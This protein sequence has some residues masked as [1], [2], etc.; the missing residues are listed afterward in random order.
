[1]R[2]KGVGVG[3]LYFYVHFVT[4][5]IC[6]TLL[7]R[8][9]CSG[10]E[11]WALYL[12]YDMLAF[13]PQG[14][15]GAFSDR[16]SK[17]PVGVIGMS[18]MAAAVP[19]SVFVPSPYVSITV[20]C[21]GNACVHVDGAEVTLRCSRG[22]LSSSAIFVSGGSFGVV[23]GQLLAR[24]SIS[25]WALVPLAATAIPFMLLCG[26]HRR[27][28]EDG[29]PVPCE[30]FRYV[31]KGVPAGLAIA[32]LVFIVATRSYMGYGI[33]TSWKTET[34]QTVLLFSVMGAGKA[35]GGVF[36][37]LIGP[38]RVA[39]LSAALALPFLMLGDRLIAVSL[40]G[41]FFFSMTMAVTL[42]ALVSVT[43]EYP[44]LAF[45]LTTV[46]LFLGTAPVFFFRFT[47]VLSNCIVIAALTA[48][49]IALTFAVMRKDGD[50]DG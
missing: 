27:E 3:F 50:K 24:G 41:V 1:M 13:V 33:P 19:L 9:A 46:G 11:Q 21:I 20:L 40:I 10:P 44:G 39:V 47:G 17:V 18:L 49:C 30:N 28:A 6:F 34:W 25:V 23:T 16:F 48:V 31:K 5:V 26:M 2:P 12:F 32:A 42:A 37:D 35:L 36:S 7:G 22:T 8:Y 14:I 29:S 15:V 43:P 4:E 38:R 45:G